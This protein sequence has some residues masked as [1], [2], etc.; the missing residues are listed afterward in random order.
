MSSQVRLDRI[1]RAAPCLRLL[2]DQHVSIEWLDPRFA[3]LA[4]CI[5][6]GGALALVCPVRTSLKGL[7]TRLTSLRFHRWY[8]RSIVGKADRGEGRFDAFATPFSADI[9]PSRLER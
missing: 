2:C 7:I 5:A 9:S 8:Y 6:V 3:E 1:S 4:R